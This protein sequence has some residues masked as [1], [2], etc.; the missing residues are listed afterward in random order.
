MPTAYP[1][2]QICEKE[3][4]DGVDGKPQCHYGVAFVDAAVG[5]I[6]VGQFVDDRLSSRLRTLLAHWPP[7]QILFGKGRWVGRRAKGRNW[8]DV[9]GFSMRLRSTHLYKGSCPFFRASLDIFERRTWLF[10]NMKVTNRRRRRRRHQ[11][12]WQLRLR[13]WQDIIPLFFPCLDNAFFSKPR[14][15]HHGDFSRCIVILKV[16]D[17]AIT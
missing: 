6:V 2:L 10:F 4:S 9:N 15:D 8:K 11:Q 17:I 16:K 5:K 1:W 12:R 3:I 14:I 13:R 7:Q